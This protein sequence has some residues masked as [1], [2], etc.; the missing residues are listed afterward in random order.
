[1]VGCSWIGMLQAENRVSWIRS[2]GLSDTESQTFSLSV[3]TYIWGHI[4]GYRYVYVY[5]YINYRVCAYIYIYIPYKNKHTHI[6]TCVY[7]YM[8]EI[9]SKLEGPRH[10]FLVQGSASISW[11][12]CKT[13]RHW[14]PFL[15][16]WHL[17]MHNWDINKTICAHICIYI[18]SPINE[19][20]GLE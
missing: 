10:Q 1:M 20:R 16:C 12:S 17:F 7:I 5:I 4:K 9:S 8:L 6:H 2:I 11:C 14:P 13:A 19:L 15:N 3:T 18:Y